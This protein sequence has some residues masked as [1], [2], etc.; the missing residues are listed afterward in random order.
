MSTATLPQATKVLEIITQKK[1]TSDRLQRLLEGG[2]LADLMEAN[3][4]LNRDE[5]RACL[6]IGKLHPNLLELEGIVIPEDA[7]I[8]N[9]KIAGEYDSQSNYAKQY[10]TDK[11]FKV[12]VTGPRRP[13]L[14]HFNKTV[15]SQHVEEVAE[16]MGY[17]VALVED[18]LSV[19]SH[20]EHRKLQRQF[21]IIALGSSAVL[22][23]FRRVPCLY[24]WLD[25]RELYLRCY[26]GGW[27]GHCRFLLV[28]KDTPPLDA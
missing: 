5:F 4:N 20:P 13:Y 22:Y 10:L 21:P 17:E 23:G 9:L 24:G 27:A 12:T 7:T 8:A 2:F 25:E 16:E 18:L 28:G 1:V 14:A 6:K 11:H 15:T 3:D 19:G 26:D